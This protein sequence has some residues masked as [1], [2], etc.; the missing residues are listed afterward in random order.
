MG[1]KESAETRRELPR[2]W[3]LVVVCGQGPLCYHA[4]APLRGAHQHRRREGGEAHVQEAQAHR[5]APAR[6]DACR[7][8][9]GGTG[10]R[11]VAPDGRRGHAG[12]QAAVQRLCL[13]AWRARRCQVQPCEGKACMARTRRT[14]RSL[15]GLLPFS[16]RRLNA[17][18]FPQARGTFL[19]AVPHAGHSQHGDTR[20]SRT[21][22]LA[23]RSTHAHATKP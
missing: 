22:P 18:A 21:S 1:A 7:Q 5:P 2:R 23:S 3:R 19:Q 16:R 13:R 4:A 12:A 11:R 9:V 10:E 14:G 20:I 15:S 8:A 17:R 6:G